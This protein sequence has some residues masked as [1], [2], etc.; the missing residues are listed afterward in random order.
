MLNEENEELENEV[1]RLKEENA[2]HKEYC[3]CFENEKLRLDLSNARNLL[4]ECQNFILSAR[5]SYSLYPN[6]EKII[7]RINAAIG[8]NE[9]QDNQVADI[10]IQESEAPDETR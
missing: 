5:K 10:K 4:K 8:D 1:K 3:C 6:P 9:I 7:N 2:Q